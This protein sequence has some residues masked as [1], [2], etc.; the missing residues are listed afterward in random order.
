VH[1]CTSLKKRAHIN[2]STYGEETGG[3]YVRDSCTKMWRVTSLFHLFLNLHSVTECDNL[4]CVFKW[5]D[6]CPQMWFW[7]LCNH[8]V[9]CNTHRSWS[10]RILAEGNEKPN[11][12]C[13][14]LHPV[15]GA[16]GNVSRSS[17]KCQVLALQEGCL[18]SS[19]TGGSMPLLC[20]G[21]WW[22]LRE[23]VVVGVT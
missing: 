7:P 2:C 15:H 9:F 5:H 8:A 22:L 1:Q 17:V 4:L 3:G 6:F 21:R 12:V 23:V 11:Q 14:S 20:R 19:W 18:K 16:K 13:I 10:Y